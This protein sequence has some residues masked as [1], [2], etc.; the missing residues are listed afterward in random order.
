MRLTSN[1]GNSTII[2]SVVVAMALRILPW[3]R[4]TLIFN[5]DWVLLV[6]I[7]WCLVTPERFSIGSSWFVGLLTD[8]LTGQLLGEHALSYAVIAYITVRLHKR[9]RIFP[10][11]QQ[12]LIVLLLLLLSQLLIYWSQNIQGNTGIGLSYWLPSFIGAMLW[13]LIFISLEQAG[14]RTRHR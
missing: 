6:V 10:L 7:Y 11:S 1:H 14:F 8:V 3:P 2:L 9:F 4:D 13:P 5:P 12:F